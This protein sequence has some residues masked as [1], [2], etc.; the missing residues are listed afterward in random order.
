[1][2][3]NISALEF[4]YT[5]IASILFDPIDLIQRIKNTFQFIFQ[6]FL[7]ECKLA[8]RGQPDPFGVLVGNGRRVMIGRPGK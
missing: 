2:S 4:L 6:A 5:C 3:E 8:A 7:G 1:M